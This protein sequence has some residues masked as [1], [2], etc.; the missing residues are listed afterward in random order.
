MRQEVIDSTELARII[1]ENSPSP[2]IV[3]GTDSERKRSTLKPTEESA[4]EKP[5]G[6]AGS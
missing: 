5:T 4:A 6:S 1:E 2:M 3:P